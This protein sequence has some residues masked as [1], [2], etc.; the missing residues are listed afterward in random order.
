MP[1]FSSIRLIF[2]GTG[3]SI[4]Q[5][6]LEQPCIAL[7][8]DEKILLLDVGEHCQKIFEVFRLGSNS[9]LYIFI[10]HL[11]SDHY[12]G[13]RPLLESLSLLGRHNP[14]HILGPSGL[15]HVLA[16]GFEKLDFPVYITELLS[17]EGVIGLLNNALSVTYVS[18]PHSL[19]ALSYVFK[20]KEK[21]KLDE[22]KLNEARVPKKL[23]RKLLSEKKVI[24]GDVEYNL[25]DFVKQVI[26]G[27]KISYSGDTL[28]SHR[29]AA[30][31]LNSD[32][33]IHEATL[34]RDDWYEKPYIAHSSVEDALFIAK[35][36]KVKLLVL[37]HFSARYRDLSKLASRGRASFPRVIFAERGLT[38]SIFFSYP[39]V[40]KIDWHAC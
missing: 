13:L 30:K 21:I 26:P 38:V 12:N 14:V 34:L 37:F 2:W 19:H 24:S 9:P 5:G 32:V 39:R 25:K 16:H 4:A 10:S 27:V 15:R 3:G 20:T 31:A 28:P 6:S 8:L 11:H 29:F 23:R 17:G 22:D 35:K 40:F 18:A 36:A 7:Q 1:E 33:L